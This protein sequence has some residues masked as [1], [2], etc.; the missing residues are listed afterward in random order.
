MDALANGIAS[1][2]SSL[3]TFER[4][5]REQRGEVSGDV[6]KDIETLITHV[7]DEAHRLQGLLGGV[8]E[9]EVGMLDVPEKARR[10][11]PGK[12][13]DRGLNENVVVEEASH[14]LGRSRQAKQKTAASSS[15]SPSPSPASPAVKK[16]RKQKDGKEPIV[17]AC[18]KKTTFGLFSLAKTPT[19]AIVLYD[20]D[21]VKKRGRDA[22]LVTVPVAKKNNVSVKKAELESL[23][24]EELPV[25]QQNSVTHRLCAEILTIAQANLTS[26]TDGASGDEV[27]SLLGHGDGNGGDTLVESARVASSFYE[28]GGLLQM[29]AQ[30]SAI[31]AGFREHERLAREEGL[32]GV[33]KANYDAALQEV[34]D[35]FHVNYGVESLRR[36]HSVGGL[37][38]RCPVLML[39]NLLTPFKTQHLIIGK[40]LDRPDLKQQL[41]VVL[42]GKVFLLEEPGKGPRIEMMEEDGNDNQIEM[43]EPAKQTPSSSKKKNVPT[44][45]KSRGC[46]HQMLECSQ[47]YAGFCPT[48]DGDYGEGVS[49][50]DPHSLDYAYPA[51]DPITITLLPLYVYCKECLEDF[52][53][54][55]G[56]G[57][58]AKMMVLENQFA[59]VVRLREYFGA[60]NCEFEW[61]PIRADG[62]CLIVATATLL[63]VQVWDFCKALAAFAKDWV[64]HIENKW[65]F[66]PDSD[67]DVTV[68]KKAEFLA[69]WKSV[70]RRKSERTALEPIMQCWNSSAGD[71]MLKLIGDYLY[72]RC[73]EK[74][75]RI[76]YLDD[77]HHEA[78]NDPPQ[79]RIAG[80]Y[81]DCECRGSIEL[82]R[83]NPILPHNDALRR[84][85]K[86]V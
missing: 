72:G 2:V 22:E 55:V 45:R 74:Q 36:Y 69:I 79:L 12:K 26:L 73:G 48:C 80:S 50:F 33:T 52:D 57:M 42:H 39:C 46:T 49:A 29:L 20:P 67:E 71:M 31:L 66:L 3:T 35:S 54:R 63:E 84:K 25:E 14:N 58:E 17:A 24:F 11:S 37:F 5:L 19:G 75:L 44:K 13:R 9:H 70:A 60:P 1:V 16:K 23:S 86:I 43:A 51:R 6:R 76:Y 47:C 28:R 7:N 56:P 82:L 53:L 30:H 68:D 65:L 40:M 15:S 32:G 38:A 81:P 78:T 18:K 64:N 41:D 21:K 59:E 34:A 61:V 10:K 4:S 62:S 85:Q 83:W 27:I 77:S 8:N